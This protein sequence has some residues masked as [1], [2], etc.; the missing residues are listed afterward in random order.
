LIYSWR[1]PASIHRPVLLGVNPP[2]HFIWDPKAIDEQIGQFG[3]LCARDGGC[4]RSTDD[5]A[6]TMRR[7]ARD[8]PQ[9]WGPL[10]IKAGNGWR[11]SSA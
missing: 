3:M 7:T 11:H 1:Y 8:L 5:L 9:R 2:G 6:A 10:Q 4:S